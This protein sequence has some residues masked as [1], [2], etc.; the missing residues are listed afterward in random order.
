LAIRARQTP[1]AASLLATRRLR[2]A[3]RGSD[4]SG[5]SMPHRGVFGVRVCG[6]MPGNLL[7]GL[8]ACVITQDSDQF[9]VGSPRPFL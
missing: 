3:A 2:I 8:M 6:T 9:A 1:A 5:R 7:L 4:I